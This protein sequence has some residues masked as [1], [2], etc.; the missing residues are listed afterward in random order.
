VNKTWKKCRSVNLAMDLLKQA[1]SFS[2][3]FGGMIVALEER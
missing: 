1:H 3:D 2:I